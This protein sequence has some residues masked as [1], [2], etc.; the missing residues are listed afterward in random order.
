MTKE[1]NKIENLFFKI[2]GKKISNLESEDECKEYVGFNFQMENLNFKFR[3]SKITPKKIGQFV[4][5]WK[6][7]CKNL[8]KPF[9]ET[10]N[11]DYYIFLSEQD[12]RIGLFIF[13]KKLLIEKNIISTKLKEG[14]RGFRLYPTWVKTENKQAEKT[15]CWQTKYFIELTNNDQNNIDKLKIMIT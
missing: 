14:K 7:D 3:K 2:Y 6:R 5:I 15:Q 9:N 8:T 4:T 10:D 13:S 11:F 1:L 12:Q